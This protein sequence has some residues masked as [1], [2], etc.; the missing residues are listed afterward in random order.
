MYS[1]CTYIAENAES[2]N[3]VEGE[4]VF[5]LGKLEAFIS[6]G[7]IM[8]TCNIIRLISEKHNPDW[9]FVKKPLTLEKGWVPSQCLMDATS[10]AQYV[11]N[12]LNEKID[13]L[14]V[15]ES[16][17]LFQLLTA[18]N[19]SSYIPQPIKKSSSIYSHTLYVINANILELI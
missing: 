18:I 8:R 17:C 5:V 19:D 3:L 14:P 15:F 1:Y 2:L 16:E 11:E 7:Q 9:W 4:K 12:K 10:Y 13:K 6:R